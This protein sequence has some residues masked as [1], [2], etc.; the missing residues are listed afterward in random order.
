M[1]YPPP[2]YP[3]L[4]FPTK[5]ALRGGFLVPFVT[6]TGPAADGRGIR[7]FVA[8]VAFAMV[9]EPEPDAA[10]RAWDLVLAFSLGFPLAVLVTSPFSATVIDFSNVH[11]FSIYNLHLARRPLISL[12]FFFP[13]S[14]ISFN[15]FLLSTRTC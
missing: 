8:F 1:A 3:K 10:V 2:T 13:S 7:A 12:S 14:S 11:D 4:Y 15:F 9:P 5:R 6:P